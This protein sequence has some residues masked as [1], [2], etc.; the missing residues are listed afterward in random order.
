MEIF[1]HHQTL[2][3]R[4]RGA[5]VAIGN[6]DGVHRGHRIVIGE[7]AAVA[8]ALGTRLAVVS[9][10]PHP[11]SVFRP[12]EP[13][14]RLTPFRA[15]AHQLARLG[16]DLHIVLTFDEAFAR[17]S[18]E[19]FIGEVLVDGLA[20]RHVTIGYDFCFGHKRRGTS[21]TLLAAGRVSGFGVTVVT[22]ASDET[23]GAISSSRIRELLVE[24]RAREAAELLGRPWEIEG[25]VETGDRRGRE[26][27]YPTANIDLGEH[28]RP[29]FGVYAVRVG[30]E[31]EGMAEPE[32]HD[33]VANLGIRPMYASPRPLLEAHLFDFAGDLYGR[34]LR[35]Q[36]VEWLRGEARLPSVAALI[37]Q[38]DRDSAAA[39]RA[40]AGTP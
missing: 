2:P 23:G 30:L 22:K 14:F 38:M 20:V 12:E 4:A 5:V 32:W 8:K 36:L 6:F 26:L 40:L 31:A 13:P 10:E 17:Q 25:R 7:A 34:H 27:G 21:E 9:F 29:A 3:E 39:R 15:R 37:A 16:V 35:V 1:R 19:D 33:G 11:R 24:G 18:P 28:L